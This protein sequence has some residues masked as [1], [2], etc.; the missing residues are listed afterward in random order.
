VRKAALL[1]AGVVLALVAVTAGTAG[2]QA[3]I[4]SAQIKDGTIQS[5]DIKNGSIGRA[6]IS[7]AATASLRGQ[8]GA[9]GPQGPAGAAGAQG[10][11]GATGAQG[12]QGPQ[13]EKGAQGDKGE[14]G[15]TGAEGAKG[16]PGAGVHVTG[17]VPTAADLPPTA[18][19]G[20]AYIALDTG[21]LH[22]WD[23]DSFVDTGPVLGPKGDKG[24]QGDVGPA[25]PKGDQGIPGPAGG[26]SGYQVVTGAPVAITPDDFDVSTA[27]ACPAGK[28]AVGGGVSIGDPSVSLDVSQSYPAVDGSG[29]NSTVH[30]YSGTSN[31][32]TPYAICANQA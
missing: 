7:A 14:K 12:A 16:D 8:R 29:W 2:V 3:L 13:G 32:V 25:G 19:E 22:V 20:D 9:A 30:N 5:R 24:E 15:D 26:L 17:S 11:Q 6:D 10:P 4:T 27:A 1:T 31:S 21:N 18:D 23:G 28:V